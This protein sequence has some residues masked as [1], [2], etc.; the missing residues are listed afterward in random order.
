M[1]IGHFGL[2]IPHPTPEVLL[3]NQWRPTTTEDLKASIKF[4]L[5][6]PFGGMADE[7]NDLSG[8]ALNYVFNQAE[9]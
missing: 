7:L 4:A 5:T 1:S 3:Q 8:A 9:T 2:E 6:V